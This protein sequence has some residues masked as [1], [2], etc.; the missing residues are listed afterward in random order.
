M[1]KVIDITR[2]F[3]PLEVIAKRLGVPTPTLK[4]IAEDG[5]ISYLTVGD[6]VVFSVDSIRSYIQRHQYVHPLDL[7]GGANGSR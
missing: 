2:Q 6:D 7:I 5:E 4:K 1:G 3:Y